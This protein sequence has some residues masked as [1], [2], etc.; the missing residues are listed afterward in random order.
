[1]E[2]LEQK[3]H[4]LMRDRHNGQVDAWE[5][6]QYLHE[7]L[8]PYRIPL[9]D[10]LELDRRK[11]TNPAALRTPEAHYRALVNLLVHQERAK[12][13]SGASRLELGMLQAERSDKARRRPA[14]AAPVCGHCRCTAGK[15]LVMV[16]GKAVP[17]PACA[18][19]AGAAQV[20]AA[21]AR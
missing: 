14:T 11:T 1:M 4:A 6:I 15:G 13:R 21:E 10:F 5:L 17:C 7:H 20:P 9:S 3:I 18:T 12:L 2:D 8:D 16:D 19:Q